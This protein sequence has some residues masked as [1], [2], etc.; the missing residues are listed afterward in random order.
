MLCIGF[1]ISSGIGDIIRSPM[2]Q[3][4]KKMPRRA[5]T[6][7]FLRVRAGTFGVFRGFSGNFHGS[8]GGFLGKT[9][10][11]RVGLSGRGCDRT[12]SLNGIFNTDHAS[13]ARQMPRR[14]FATTNASCLKYWKKMAQD[15]GDPPS[16]MGAS[17]LWGFRPYLQ[18]WICHFSP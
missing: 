1:D 15:G 10:R 4:P 3:P 9:C 17:T 13:V 12:L 16:C 11:N 6:M 8:S 5:K 7:G 2:A 18:W 14:T